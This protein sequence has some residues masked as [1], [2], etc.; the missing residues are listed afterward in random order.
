[1]EVNVI[2]ENGGSFYESY[3]SLSPIS[4]VLQRFRKHFR[5]QPTKPF[6]CNRRV[7]Y[8]NQRQ[9]TFYNRRP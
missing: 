3:F 2:W 1:M 9:Q 7:L 5:R 6:G 8:D 4:G